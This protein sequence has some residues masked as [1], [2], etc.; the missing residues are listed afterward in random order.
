M[1]DTGPPER[2]QQ[3]ALEQFVIANCDLETLEA[4]AKRFNIFEALGVVRAERTH[5]KFLGFLLNPKES[6]GLGSRFLKRFLQT[7]LEYPPKIATVT[8]ADVDLSDLSQAEICIECDDMDV[9]IRDARG[10]ISVIIENKIYSPQHSGQLVRY[11]RREL[12]RYPKRNI[13]GIYLTINGDDP[14][15]EHYASISHSAIRR[16]VVDL[17]D[18]DHGIDPG[19]QFALRQYADLIGRHFMPDEDVNELCEKLYEDHRQAIDLIMADRASRKPRICQKL[20]G[21]VEADRRL[22]PDECTETLIRFIPKA[23]DLPCFKCG[24]WWKKHER[25]FLFEFD[26]RNKV[27]L[28]IQ[29]GPGDPEMRKHIHEFALENNEVFQ[30]DTDLDSRWQ[31]LFMKPIVEGLDGVTGQVQ[32]V[33]TIESKWREFLENDLPRIEQA[34]LAHQWPTEA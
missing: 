26:I 34:F 30:T 15:N 12:D 21:L 22:D 29:L 8:P 11:Y 5:S 13:L 24:T 16:L 17:L 23:I 1:D 25:L 6:H 32:L 4:L 7:A 18:S 28:R 33:Q 19:V 14:E 2:D 31:R 20:K 10:N 27:I 3:Q 9:I